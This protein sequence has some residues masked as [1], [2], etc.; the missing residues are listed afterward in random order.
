MKVKL[1][2]LPTRIQKL[3]KLSNELGQDIYIKRDDETG[4]EISGNKIRKLE[5]ALKEALEQKCTVVITTGALQSNHCRATAAACA[6]LG[7]ACHL[8]VDGDDTDIVEGNFFLDLVFG[9]EVHLIGPEVDRYEVMED[10]RESL[11]AEGEKAYPI[12]I[13]ASNAVGS[14]GYVEAAD[15]IMNWEEV[16]DISFDNI[17]L[18]VGSGGT[19]SGLYYQLT[20]SS[21]DVELLGFSVN[22]SKEDFKR[23]IEDILR[24]MDH[25]QA[26]DTSGIRIID[27][28]IGEGYGISSRE[29][30]EIIK[31]LGADEAL[32]LD[33]VYTAKA[34]R[35]MVKEIEEER[36]KGKTLFI[37]TG[38]VFGWTEKQRKE[39]LSFR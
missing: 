14:L 1:A 33:P 16:N 35:G 39:F 22:H 24:D 19:Y 31:R 10:L 26:I 5:Y 8:I 3:D 29:D 28:Y 30:Y 9:A 21:R 23:I 27:D 37:H 34:F 6:K 32:I 20:K 12:F 36:I 2:N 7:L 4:L 38:G 17:V 15:E 13:G 11:E 18:A 25:G